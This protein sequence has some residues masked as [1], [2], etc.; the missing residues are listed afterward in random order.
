ML[1]IGMLSAIFLG[2]YYKICYHLFLPHRENFAVC[3]AAGLLAL[4]IGTVYVR[5]YK[6]TLPQLLSLAAFALVL[7]RW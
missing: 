2:F 4:T 7:I 5:K 1:V 6:A 3:T